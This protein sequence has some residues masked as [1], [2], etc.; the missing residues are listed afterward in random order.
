MHHGSRFFNLSPVVG[1]KERTLPLIRLLT[2]GI[3]KLIQILMTCM[4]YDQDY[5][6]G[7]RKRGKD[8]KE[9]MVRW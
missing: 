2:T 5:Y 8:Y 9:G 6:P 7:R 1:K 4:Q 3:R